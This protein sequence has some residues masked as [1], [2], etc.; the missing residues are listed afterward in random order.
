[1]S[2][3]VEK[4]LFFLSIVFL[5]AMAVFVYGMSVA[6]FQIW[7]YPMVQEVWSAIKS[8]REHGEIDPKNLFV[9]VPVDAARVTFTNYKPESQLD[10][11]YGFVGYDHDNSVYTAW[12]FDRDGQELHRWLLDYENMDSDGPL[13]GGDS[14]HAF[15]V[16]PD[17]SVIVS[18]DHGDVM[19]RLDSCGKPVWTQSGVY[20]HALKAAEDGSYWTWRGEGTSNAQYHYLVNFKPGT[21]ETITEIG[22]VED[23]IKPMGTQSL[24]FGVRPDHDFPHF[25]TT[26][27]PREPTDL[28]HPNG[29][30]VLTADLAPLFPGFAAG[31]LL[32]SFRTNHLLAILDPD[33]RQIKWWSHGPWRFQHDPDF[34]ADG[35]ISVFSNNSGNGRSEI[36]K[37]DP[38]SR[39]VV[40]ELYDGELNFYSEFMGKHQYLP[41]GN[42]LVVIPGEGRVLEVTAT[43]DKVME[44]NNMSV[45][46]AEQNVHMENGL[47]VPAGYFDE[48]PACL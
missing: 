31:D 2:E 7:P 5:S 25:K 40:N 44:F 45:Y 23:I 30:D 36:I 46:S 26:P 35:K 12:L 18:F 19:A 47:W 10:G 28:F 15:D 24:I 3:T 17:G 9:Q 1:M 27:E 29:I 20:H 11:K 42:I 4:R 14:P 41:N 38:V 48:L 6:K 33:T 16:L 39:L 34:T 43:G 13:N 37:I 8:V 22:L 21:G 32:L